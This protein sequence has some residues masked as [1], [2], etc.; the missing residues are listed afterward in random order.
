ML[1]HYRSLGYKCDIKDEISVNQKDLTEG[2]RVKVTL[3]CDYC[4]KEFEASN[5]SW[6]NNKSKQILKK[7]TCCYKC[8]SEYIKESNIL[9]Y[10]KENVFQVDE[11]KEK[12]KQTN[13]KRYGVEYVSQLDECKRKIR[14]T[15]IKKYGVDHYTRTNE[16]KKFINELWKNRTDEEIEEINKNRENT[17]ISRYGVRNPNQSEVIKEKIKN[18]NLKRYGCENVFQNEDIKQRIKNQNFKE[19]G[20]EYNSQRE[21]VSKKLSETWRKK[22]EEEIKET[23]EKRKQTC[24][25]KYGVSSPMKNREIIEKAKS[26]CLVKYGVENPMKNAEIKKK[27]MDK[28]NE[29]K[30]V[31]TSKQQRY[32]HNL[33]GG[34]LNYYTGYNFLDIAFIDEKIYIEY[35][36]GGH[37]LDI[38]L[39]GIS[40]DE[41]DR[42]EL[43]R[44][45]ALKKEG[46]KC[47]KIISE[48]DLLPYDDMI[49]KMV[50]DCKNIL[51]NNNNW[52]ELNIDKK[53]IKTFSG[54]ENYDFGDLRRIRWEV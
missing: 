42:K 36:G 32:I 43:K 2:S 39:G 30:L 38:K 28:L 49:T 37:R 4:G 9:K 1:E 47:I 11:F 10:G 41:F 20:V 22:T 5:K 40:K 21:D 24:L 13:L 15:C 52:V 31:A 17:C 16:Y 3:V 18:T 44:Y 53:T 8:R 54:E 6:R 46:W 33:I 45:F 25:E 34:I 48:K 27:L 51:K 50:D 12:Q 26:T 29:D 14:N 35:D 19:Y 7:D 23:S